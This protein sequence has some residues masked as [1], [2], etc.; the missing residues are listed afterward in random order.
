[1]LAHDSRE[2]LLPQESSLRNLRIKDNASH[3]VTEGG[4]RFVLGRYVRSLALALPLLLP[5]HP[6][7]TARA[8]GLD[9]LP[10]KSRHLE[11][12]R[13]QAAQSPRSE[14]DQAVIAGWP[15][16][17]TERGQMAFNDAMA[18]LVASEGAAP[19]ASAFKGC[20]ALECPLSL[21]PLE[22]SGWLTPGRIWIS[23]SEYVLLV[24]SP[25]LRDGQTYRRRPPRQMRVFVFHEFHNSSRNT[26]LYDTISSHSGA[27]FVPF[28]MSKPAT[29]A[30]GRRFVIVT[31]VAP[32][33]VVSIHAT[34]RGSAGPG[35]EVA[36]NASDPVEPLQNLAG[37]IVATSLKTA[38]PNL[39][40]V[41][42]RG[43]EGMPM[44]DAFERRLAAIRNN[45]KATPLA[46]P[47]VPAQPQ[48]IATA[49]ASLTA[50]IA[51]AGVSPRIPMADRGILPRRMASVTER[52]QPVSLVGTEAQL[53]EPVTLV[54]P[55]SCSSASEA[56]AS[57]SCRR[58][59]GSQ[60]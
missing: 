20:V 4:F 42:H 8:A 1:M 24:R 39:Q 11:T 57:L 30:I 22:P 49:S 21:P 60:Q 28:Y 45:A 27:V 41:N 50:V 44:L 59:L 32:Y 14:G 40:V 46:L 55:P 2:A 12:P 3:R 13:N 15:L 48:R 51:R 34:N 18:T 56:H 17:R 29:D 23:P 19:S 6:L 54:L 5:L 38:A 58:R 10:I 31:Q 26:D 7:G 33:D 16:Y 9:A 43:L 25:R 36:R 37:V 35:I 52:P 53:I 47:F